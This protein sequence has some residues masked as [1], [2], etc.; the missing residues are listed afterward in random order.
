M[1]RVGAVTS[2][3]PASRREQGAGSAPGRGEGLGDLRNVTQAVPPR[4][5]RAG[6]TAGQVH[7][8]ATK[9]RLVTGFAANIIKRWYQ[10]APR[11][12]PGESQPSQITAPRAATGPHKSPQQ[13]RS[14][15]VRGTVLCREGPAAGMGLALRRWGKAE[16]WRLKLCQRLGGLE[17]TKINTKCGKSPKPRNWGGA[18]LGPLTHSRCAR[19]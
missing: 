2:Q 12:L 5:A 13:T 10:R 3:L 11:S 19:H 6:V 1:G 15:G 4:R 17:E 7:T 18:G 14:A 16:N 8:K 9:A